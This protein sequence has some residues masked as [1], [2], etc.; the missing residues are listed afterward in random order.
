MMIELMKDKK[1]SHMNDIFYHS[2]RL[3]AN[4][5]TLFISYGI[6]RKMLTFSK[7]NT[8][9]TIRGKNSQKDFHFF[10][11]QILAD[12]KDVYFALKGADK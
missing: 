8:F 10:F 9:N 12:R 5:I 4:E 3:T 2:S 11:A 6:K 7:M 1:K